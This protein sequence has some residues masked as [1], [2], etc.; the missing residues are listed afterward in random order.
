MILLI[1]AT[2]Q[3]IT[4]HNVINSLLFLVMVFIAVTFL[5]IKL[6]VEYIGMLI[7]IV[8]LG[9]MM[10]LFLFVVMLLDIRSIELHH[11]FF[12]YH[13]IGIFLLFGTGIYV[14]SLLNLNFIF[15]NNN[16]ESIYFFIDNFI[17]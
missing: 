3:V 6:N 4:Q 1:L 10:V 5:L 16:I 17:H 14:F 15:S 7:L 11:R 13:I 2:V 9:A 12:S 8:Y